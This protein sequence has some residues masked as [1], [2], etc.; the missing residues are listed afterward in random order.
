MNDQTSIN[1]KKYKKY[2]L[3]ELSNLHSRTI[4]RKQENHDNVRF[5]RAKQFTTMLQFTVDYHIMFW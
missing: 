1:W 5:T 3:R 2:N 4:K